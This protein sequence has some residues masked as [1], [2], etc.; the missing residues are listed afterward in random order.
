MDKNSPAVPESWRAPT[1]YY[2]GGG[3]V[4]TSVAQLPQ[5]DLTPDQVRALI[6][7]DELHGVIGTGFYSRTPAAT[8]TKATPAAPVA[9]LAPISKEADHVE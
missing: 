8:P 1:L 6:P 7:Q 9:D 2:R 5:T 4:I 3:S